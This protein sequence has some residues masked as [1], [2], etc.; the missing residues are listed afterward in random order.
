MRRQTDPHWLDYFRITPVVDD[1][2]CPPRS[3]SV[4][5][6]AL[7]PTPEA[8]CSLCGSQVD[9][10]ISRAL[11]WPI[12]AWWRHGVGLRTQNS[13]QLPRLQTFRPPRFCW[14]WGLLRLVGYFPTQPLQ[15]QFEILF[16]PIDGQWRI[17]GLT[18]R[19][20]APGR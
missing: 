8:P 14:S 11:R 5:R 3:W 20:A 15:I 10:L 1:A 12:Q 16:Q 4:E 13:P 18:V 17:F 19:T 6:G 9:R 2:N 7:N